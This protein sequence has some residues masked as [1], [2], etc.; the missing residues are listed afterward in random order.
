MKLS[1]RMLLIIV[2]VF[3]G[4]SWAP[5]AELGPFS[6]EQAIV[7]G[8]RSA[9][10]LYRRH[11]ADDLKLFT[12]RAGKLQ[13][14]CEGSFRDNSYLDRLSRK[15]TLKN[16][17]TMR[18]IYRFWNL[19]RSFLDDLNFISRK[20]E[21]PLIFGH[22]EKVK[23]FFA[24]YALGMSARLAQ[25]IMVSEMMNFL[26]RRGGLEDLLNE[27][28]EEY[29]IPTGSFSKA[30]KRSLS[31]EN[32][33]QLYRFRISHFEEI[34]MAND[35][36]LPP[37]V[38]GYLLAH[39][40]FLNTLSRKVASD[41]TWKF[42]SRSL[43]NASLELVLPAQRELFT[44]VGDTRVKNQHSR[45]ISAAQL[46]KF[47]SMLQPGDILVG[48]QDYYLSNIFLPGFWPHALLYVGTPAEISATFDNDPE[49]LRWCKRYDAKN[50][51]GLLEKRYNKA[52]STWKT[53][54]PAD[55]KPRCIMEAISEGIVINS[56]PGALH[57]DYVAAVRPR[58][59]KVAKAHAIMLALSYFGREYDFQFSFN[60]EQSLV[61]TEL[62]TKAYSSQVDGHGLRFPMVKSLG[63]YGIPADSI[64]KDFADRRGRSDRQLDFI[65]F[66]K[67]LPAKKTAVF[68]DESEFAESC[69]WAGGLKSKNTR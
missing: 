31:T 36:A 57:C 9:E 34:G 43:I 32:L 52:F 22:K 25:V 66:I 30:I 20:Y 12:D 46:E 18:P 38:S 10:S 65:A 63:N 58:L 17:E 13:R 19:F 50:F 21:V 14:L 40:D 44:W 15:D 11:L 33:A 35:N 26:A 41:P 67:G 39:S 23:N 55:G 4:S 60:T 7:E 69:T 16:H 53:M 2:L 54:N 49:M 5:A 42:L 45:L 62:V 59:S 29:G 61:C 24:G 68:A 48:R 3:C 64:V 28:N 1:Q 37:T 47:G 51:T 27:G 56:L 8:S 6:F